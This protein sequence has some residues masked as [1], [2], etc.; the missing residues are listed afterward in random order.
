MPAFHFVLFVLSFLLSVAGGIENYALIF[1]VRDLFGVDRTAV[2]FI[3]GAMSLAYL[4]G[5]LLFLRWKT[6]HPRHVLWLSAWSMA[7]CVAVYLVIPTWTVTFVFHA[8]FGLAMALFW[9]RIMGWLS[10]GVEGKTLGRTMGWFNASW[11][12]GSIVAPWL[13]GLAVEL[14]S[15]LPFEISAALLVVLGLLIP[16]A[17]R[18]FPQMKALAPT[19]SHETGGESPAAATTPPALS[20]LRYSARMAVGAS[21][22]FSG[23]LMFIFPAWAKDTL[24]FSESLTGGLLLARMAFASLGFLAWGRWTFWHHRVWPMAVGLLAS[25]GLILLFPLGH[26]PWQFLV[27]F[28]TAGLLFS[29]LYSYALFHGVSGS[30]NRERSMTLH[31]AMLNIGLFLGTV[32]GGWVSQQWS[33]TAAFVLCAVVMVGILA[34]ALV[35]ARGRGARLRL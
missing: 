34:L 27:L 29:F 26:E 14:D 2:G 9:P 10:W 1:Y 16:L 19:I 18:L 8:L 24:G 21:Y 11:S 6:W 35:V 31:E 30:R 25:T 22:F 4:A 28:A 20:S 13:G 3:S 33:M 17:S 12:A 23:C 7:A 5:I 32:L 15:R